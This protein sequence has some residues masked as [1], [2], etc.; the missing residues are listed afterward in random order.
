[1][2]QVKR[3]QHYFAFV[4]SDNLWREFESIVADASWIVNVWVV[5]GGQVSYFGRLKWVPRR[6]K[7]QVSPNKLQ[8]VYNVKIGERTPPSMW[9]LW[10]NVPLW[11]L[12]LQGEESTFIWSVCSADYLCKPEGRNTRSGRWNKCLACHVCDILLAENKCSRF[13]FKTLTMRELTCPELVYPFVGLPACYPG[14]RLGA[15]HLQFTLQTRGPLHPAGRRTEWT[16]KWF[17]LG[18]KKWYI[19]FE[20]DRKHSLAS[21]LQ[22]SYLVFV[23]F[24]VVNT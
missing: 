14:R 23:C 22:F 9:N 16:G 19:R 1:M 6:E 24:D 8:K 4:I 20:P 15:Q 17:M 13:S 18:I 7:Q 10:G 21:A 2:M 3:T 12:D 5:D 11:D